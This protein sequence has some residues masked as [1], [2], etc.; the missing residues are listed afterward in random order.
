MFLF[1]FLLVSSSGR[2]DVALGEKKDKATPRKRG[3]D[4]AYRIHLPDGD[5]DNSDVSRLMTKCTE[6]ISK[7]E[8][9]CSKRIVSSDRK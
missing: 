5:L 4:E 6:P 3:P 2:T 1:V 9:A 7:E 8:K